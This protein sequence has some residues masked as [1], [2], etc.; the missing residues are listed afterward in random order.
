[1]T[2]PCGEC[3]VRPICT[4]QCDKSIT[5]IRNKIMDFKPE[6]SYVTGD[7]F[8]YRIWRDI[9]YRPNTNITRTFSYVNYEEAA[10]M[11]IVKDC[12]IVKIKQIGRTI[13]SVDKL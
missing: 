5:Y 2:N 4:E 3:I 9:I 6:G 12:S 13:K 7:S 8:I 11:I 1:M 10:C